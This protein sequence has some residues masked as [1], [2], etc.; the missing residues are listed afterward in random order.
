MCK[1]SYGA[2]VMALDNRNETTHEPEALGIS[3]ILCKK[4]TIAAIFLIDYTLPQVAKL[5]KTLQTENLD[6]TAIADLVDATLNALN[7]ASVNWVL[8]LL[9]ANKP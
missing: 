4:S 8:E 7:D 1:A 2:I 6:V 5:S 9:E 3:N